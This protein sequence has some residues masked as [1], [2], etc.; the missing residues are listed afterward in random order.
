MADNCDL[1]LFRSK[2][3]ACKF[4][5]GITRSKYDHVG[6]IVL[7]ETEE[8][9]NT[10]YLLEAVMADGVRLVEFIPN[11]DAYREVYKTITYRPLQNW[12]RTE[13]MLTDLDKFL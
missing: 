9:V 11:I 5:R 1:M 10:I 3:L 13:K 8:N 12:E 6:M 4:Q 2:T 7:W